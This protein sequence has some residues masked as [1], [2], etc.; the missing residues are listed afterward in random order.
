MTL[1]PKQRSE[2]LER[3]AAS[4]D[5]HG[6][7]GGDHLRLLLF[8]QRDSVDC[9]AHTSVKLICPRSSRTP[10]R[11]LPVQNMGLSED[12]E[13]YLRTVRQPQE[14][15]VQLT[16]SFPIPEQGLGELLAEDI[17]ACLQAVQ[18]SQELVAREM[19]EILNQLQR[20]GQA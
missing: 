8:R 15:S 20:R 5:L 1:D 2:F 19:A 17:E 11:C 7:I 14:R 9:Y 4:G 12:I 3:I 16:R 18:P 6:S 13:A 10:A